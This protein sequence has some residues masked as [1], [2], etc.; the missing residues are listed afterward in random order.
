MTATKGVYGIYS[1]L[2]EESDDML[3]KRIIAFLIVVSLLLL[4]LLVPAEAYDPLKTITTLNMSIMS[5][6]RIIRERNRIV[7]N[8]EYENII[9][10]LK[11]GDVAAD[12]EMV[13]LQEAIMDHITGRLINLR[14]E[15]LVKRLYE[16][17]VKKAL[18]ESLGNIRA[19]GGSLPSVMLS[20]LISA[21]GAFFNYH[22]DKLSYQNELDKEL[23][24]L[25]KQEIA[26]LDSLQ[27]QLLSSSWYLLNKYELGDEYRITQDNINLFL[28]AIDEKNPSVAIRKFERISKLFEWYYPFWFYYGK[29]AF[30]VGDTRTALTCFE[31]FENVRRDILR[32]DPIYAEMCKVKLLMI[33]NP[34]EKERCADIIVQNSFPGKDWSNYIAAALAYYDVG[35]YEKAISTLQT[36]L[37]YNVATEITEKLINGIETRNIDVIEFTAEM[38]DWL[39]FY[40]EMDVN[41]DSIIL[42]VF[43]QVYLNGVSSIDNL[44]NKYFYLTI[45]LGNNIIWASDKMQTKFV[46]DDQTKTYYGILDFK[47]SKN[48]RALLRLNKHIDATVFLMS[49]DTSELSLAG[50][51]IGG[52]GAGAVAGAAIGAI[53]G[54]F[55]GGL[56]GAP[57]G[58]RVGAVIGGGVGGVTMPGILGL[59]KL[60]NEGDA[61]IAVAEKNISVKKSDLE[62]LR[63]ENI[64]MIVKDNLI[65]SVAL[66]RDFYEA[67][68]VDQ[69]NPGFK[70]CLI[71]ESLQMPEAACL[72]G[73]EEIDKC[74]YYIE[75]KY[76]E[77]K[78]RI[79]EK[80]TFKLEPGITKDIEWIGVIID[81]VKVP[82]KV[83]LYEED[84]I[85]SDD[86]IFERYFNAFSGKLFIDFESSEAYPQ[87]GWVSFSLFG[88]LN[89]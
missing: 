4:T 64:P 45:A 56:A 67:P 73:E 20:A 14:E 54:L 38:V 23:W 49:S 30:E 62:Y 79:P 83:A 48:N 12:D 77:R 19:Y 22:N 34:Q 84:K 46:Y 63:K 3:R 10:N 68:K 66:R 75:L 41:Y 59:S 58:A 44:K 43:N 61:I 7:L 37:D 52:A 47:S 25:H 35:L 15:E 28:D 65:N 1:S 55:T 53:I 85:G 88:P 16:R 40:E 36:N 57:V 82:V 69:V 87:K 17:N 24:E 2:F 26:D 89:E 21:G 42:F 9:N 50:A 86:K 76:G 72:L 31:K 78:H 71:F 33:E 13:D 29:K 81:D 27:Q 51:G 39:G 11:I 32:R 70:Y 18:Y 80:G 74:D 60:L 6:S 8:Q 5:I